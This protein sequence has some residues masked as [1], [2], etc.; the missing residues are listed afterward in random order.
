MVPSDRLGTPG[1]RDCLALPRNEFGGRRRVLY[2]SLQPGCQQKPTSS[3]CCN[4]LLDRP[5]WKSGDSNATN[6]ETYPHPKC[7]QLHIH[8]MQS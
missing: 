2:T 7:N 5:D 1:C 4:P 8:S 6:P 3:I